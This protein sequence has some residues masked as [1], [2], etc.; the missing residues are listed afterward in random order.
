MSHQQRHL[1]TIYDNRRAG[2]PAHEVSAGGNGRGLP[3]RSR[4]VTG[5]RWLA[6]LVAAAAL[7]GALVSCQTEPAPAAPAAQPPAQPTSEPAAEPASPTPLP[8]A[9]VVS[10]PTPAPPT[11]SETPSVAAAATPTPV[12]PS[13]TSPALTSTPVPP[14]PTQAPATA[15]PTPPPPTATPE[16]V[17]TVAPTPS[18]S[19]SSGI[20]YN[21]LEDLKVAVGG[22]V[23]WTN[24]D[25]VSHTVTSGAPGAATTLWDSGNMGQG[26]TFKFTFSQAG[27]YAY[28]CKIH[29]SSMK[30][31]VTVE[32]Q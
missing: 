2:R 27:V 1:T 6:L 17:A 9:E 15:T 22:T 28:F 7:S 26:A 23:T 13:P 25:E 3:R 14:T 30:A 21:T 32:Q 24:G 10:S 11:L 4:S 19:V 8:A 5:Y 12:P 20:D 16:P 31:T 29:P 18:L